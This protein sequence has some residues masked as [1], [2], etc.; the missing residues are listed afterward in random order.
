MLKCFQNKQ[1]NSVSDIMTTVIVV[2]WSMMR[3]I[4]ENALSQ[5]ILILFI[6]DIYVQL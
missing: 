3:F 6:H 4:L 2:M 5:F 1:N